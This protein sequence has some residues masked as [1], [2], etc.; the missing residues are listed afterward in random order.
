MNKHKILKTVRSE[1]NLLPSPHGVMGSDF[2]P[3]K[4]M[5]RWTDKIPG[6]H[7][8]LT[9]TKYRQAQDTYGHKIPT[10]TNN[11]RLYRTKRSHKT[12]PQNIHNL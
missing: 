1:E 9:S 5:D 11:R 6:D 7:K 2:L 10:T 12:R 4:D 3:T 8:I